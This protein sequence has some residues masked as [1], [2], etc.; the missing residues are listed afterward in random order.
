MVDEYKGVLEQTQRDP[1]SQSFEELV[2]QQGWKYSS[3][4]GEAAREI[5]KY[6][7]EHRD[8]DSN[9]PERPGR[10]PGDYALSLSR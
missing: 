2:F 5:A 4:L 3:V 6:E 1:F 8:D 9:F 10:F 7:E